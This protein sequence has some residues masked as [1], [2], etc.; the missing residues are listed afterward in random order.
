[1]EALSLYWLE[2][3]YSIYS[4]ALQKE[5]AGYTRFYKADVATIAKKKLIKGEK[6]DGEGGFTVRSRGVTA[7]FSK[8]NILPL[9]LSDGLVKKDI[10]KNELITL[11]M[12]DCN[13]SEDVKVA[14]KYQYSL[15]S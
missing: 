5:P 8:K 2:L 9:G 10:E 1:M 3:A 14:R 6:L 7:E 4:V 12:V 11:N 15:I 13:F